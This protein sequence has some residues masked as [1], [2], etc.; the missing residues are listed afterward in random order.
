MPRTYEQELE[1]IER[2]SDVSFAIRKGF[3]PNMRVS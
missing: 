2:L 3:V 1:Y